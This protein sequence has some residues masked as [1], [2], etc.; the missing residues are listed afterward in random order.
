LLFLSLIIFPSRLDF[1]ERYRSAR[2]EQPSGFHRAKEAFNGESPVV[3]YLTNTT[4]ETTMKLT[5]IALASALALSSTV[6]LAQTDHRSKVH[7]WTEDRTAPM[8]QLQPNY[9]NPNG[10]PDGPTTLSGTGNSQYGGSSPGTS[11][12]N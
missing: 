6:A 9:G 7:H 5:T 10:N 8:V 12:Y 2:C 1:I 4:K 11:G 3:A